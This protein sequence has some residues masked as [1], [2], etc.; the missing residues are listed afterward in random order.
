MFININDNDQI[1]PSLSIIDALSTKELFK[2]H[3]RNKLYHRF[4]DEFV[5]RNISKEKINNIYGKSGNIWGIDFCRCMHYG[6]RPASKPRLL[7][8]IMY[9][10]R[11]HYRFPYNFQGYK[12]MNFNKIRAVVF[13]FDGVFTDNKVIVSENGTESVLCSRSDGVGIE[14]L[15]K[16]DI[17][18][19]I[20]SSE[21][22][23]V[24]SKRARKLEL[25]VVHG[26]QDKVNELYKFSDLIKIDMKNICYVGNDIND[27]ECMKLVGF[28]IAVLNAVDEIK[29]ISKY[30]LN[31]KGGDGAVRELCELIYKSY[32]N[33]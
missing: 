18:M 5:K 11:K 14:L 20:I 26:L 6:S 3:G 31:T 25:P 15:K 28:P 7:L 21:K 16:L 1:I 12:K 22:N 30:I 33:D 32:H 23:P 24:V 13:D 29:E 2:K 8:W 9:L 19:I 17:P 10:P 4:N 27:L